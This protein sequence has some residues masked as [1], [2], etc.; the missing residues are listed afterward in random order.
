MFKK[1]FRCISAKKIEVATFVELT[2]A[3]LLI[4]EDEAVIILDYVLRPR[5]EDDLPG[6][7]EEEVSKVMNN[8][9]HNFQSKGVRFLGMMFEGQ[10]ATRQRKFYDKNIPV[11]V[12]ILATLETHMAQF[13][14]GLLVW[15]IEEELIFYQENFA[16]YASDIM[17][18]AVDL[19]V[20]KHNELMQPRGKDA[21]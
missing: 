5:M 6:E 4:N 10:S 8:F 16:G 18:D 9:D 11:V 15:K 3:N 2:R 21:E 20:D 1:L 17:L 7:M 13:D 14:M 19:L 12:D